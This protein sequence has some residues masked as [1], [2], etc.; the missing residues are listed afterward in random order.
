MDPHLL[1]NKK[2]SESELSVNFESLNTVDRIVFGFCYGLF[3][4]AAGLSIAA[5]IYVI[6]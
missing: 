2:E 1:L 6:V 3:A 4:A 5:M